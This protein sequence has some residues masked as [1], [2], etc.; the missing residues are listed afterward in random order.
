M[1]NLQVQRDRIIDWYNKEKS[2]VARSEFLNIKARAMQN[3]I[4]VQ[5]STNE[6]IKAWILGL[7]KMK[8]KDKKLKPNHIHLFFQIE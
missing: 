1:H 4:N 7:L 3:S 2:Q 8:R 5:N 6:T